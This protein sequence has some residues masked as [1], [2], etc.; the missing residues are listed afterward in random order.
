MMP[1]FAVLV[2]CVLA[3]TAVCLDVLR[4]NDLA[5]TTA[6]L[7][8]VSSDP[9]GTARAYAAEHAPGTHV[10]VDTG[11]DTVTVTVGRR[12]SVRIPLLPPVPTGVPVS[13]SSVMALEPPA[14][15][16]TGG[17]SVSP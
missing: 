1:F 7:A 3:V 5:R 16:A 10:R 9:A 8:S 11:T 17:T 14:G 15:G 6:R 2:A 4:L 12:I 13:A